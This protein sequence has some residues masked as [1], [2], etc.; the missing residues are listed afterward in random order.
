MKRGKPHGAAVTVVAVLVLL[1]LLACGGT[2]GT[3]GP[4]LSTATPEMAAT[5]AP[6]QATSLPEPTAAPTDTPVSQITHLGDVLERHGYLLSVIAVEDPTTPGR[7]Y[8]PKPGKKLVAVDLIVGN[9]SGEALSV[10]PL[11]AALLDTEGFLYE[12]ELAGRDQQ[13]LTVH[14]MYGEKARG[15][16]A[17]ELPEAAIPASIKYATR[18]FAGEALQVGLTEPPEGH[19]PD[20]RALSIVPT[21]PLA[22]LG[23]VVEQYGCSLSGTTLEDPTVPGR[24]YTPRQ[25]YKLVA[26]EVVLENVSVPE[27]SVNPL[28]AILIDSSGFVYK[29][30]LGGREGQIA[31]VH[32]NAGEK[33]RGWV[34]FEVPAGAT[35]TTLKYVV[36]TFSD[37]FLET[38]LT[39]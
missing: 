20:T 38:G 15:W 18:A 17:F 30:E 36:D 27:F 29:A 32:L 39:K 19:A 13:I 21:E 22:K 6:E 34:A 8:E 26:V 5:V 25:G 12:P 1:A 11:Y 24:L 14:L 31:T 4:K 37:N 35:P 10:N 3:P 7:L 9:V 23:D 16:V 33:V 28:Y 2:S